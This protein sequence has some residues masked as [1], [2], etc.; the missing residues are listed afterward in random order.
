M[1][2]LVYIITHFAT[3]HIGTN[4]KI[5]RNQVKTTLKYFLKSSVGFYLQKLCVHVICNLYVYAAKYAEKFQTF[6]NP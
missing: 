4:C 5:A 1:S 6:K 2:T 3:C